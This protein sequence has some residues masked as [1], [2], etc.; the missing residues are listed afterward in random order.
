MNPELIK[1]GMSSGVITQEAI[2]DAVSRILRPMFSVGVMDEPVSTWDWKNLSKNVTSEASVTS[3]RRLSS[4]S[5]VLLKNDGN[6]LPLP[7][8]KKLAL[9]GF[10]GSNA[11][12]HGGGSGSVVPSHVVAPI[13]GILAAAGK[14]AEVTYNNGTDISAAAGV[15]ASADYAIVFVGTLSHEGG[16]RSS[17][18]LDDGCDVDAQGQ[19]SGGNHIQNELISAVAK[20]NSKTIV[21]ASVPGAVLMPWSGDVAAILTNFMPGQQAGNAVADVLFGKVNPSAKLPLTFP[22]KENETQLT[23]GQWPGLPNEKNPAYAFYSEKL[24]VGYRYYDAHKINFTTGFPFGHGLSY[25]SFRYSTLQVRGT[26]AAETHTSIVSFVVENIGKFDGAEVAQL[27]LSFPES[28]GEPPLQLKGFKKTRV[29]GPSEKEEVSISLRKR[30]LSIWDSHA[31]AWSQVAGTFKIMVGSS[32]RD[33]RLEGSV[34]LPQNPGSLGILADLA[35]RL[36]V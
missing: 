14:G 36:F 26:P 27:Y 11:V 2:D 19:C 3:A 12:V 7:Q 8:G 17:L 20:A 29:L 22:N 9:L 5:T 25:T 21:V 32:S 31:H 1:Q 34:T 35:E 16:D 28:S 15:A 24:L 4:I 33:I 10:A 6:V 23:P 13:E 30:D 18:S